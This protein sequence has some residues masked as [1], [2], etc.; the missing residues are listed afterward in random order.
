MNATIIVSNDRKRSGEGVPTG[1]LIVQH[2][3]DVGTTIGTGAS[4]RSNI[5]HNTAGASTGAKANRGR[6]LATLLITVALLT[7]L[8]WIGFL[9][10]VVS[11]I[12]GML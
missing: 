6:R 10:W 5:I 3:N 11:R 1:A 2:E 8:T 9:T 7:T 4:V 12:F